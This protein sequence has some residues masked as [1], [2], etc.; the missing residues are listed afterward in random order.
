MKTALNFQ[1]APRP[2]PLVTP[3]QATLLTKEAADL[4]F[5]RPAGAIVER[6]EPIVRSTPSAP[7]SRQPATASREG[8]RRAKTEQHVK[9]AIP[10]L[11]W[12]ELR[13]KAI[14]RRVTV[15]YL[16]LEA[17]SEAG[18]GVELDTIPED[19]RRHRG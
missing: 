1:P 18:Y 8:E 17:L 2:K 14:K 11:L 9:L 13:M 4:G 5:S 16:L 7:Q 10:E 19:G 12:D 3:E 6:K 15:R